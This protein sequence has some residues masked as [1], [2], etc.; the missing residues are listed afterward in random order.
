MCSLAFIDYAE[1][2]YRV[3]NEFQALTVNQKRKRILNN[4]VVS[5]ALTSAISIPTDVT[6]KRDVLQ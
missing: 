5:S 1:K 6:L 4:C 2:V 3:A